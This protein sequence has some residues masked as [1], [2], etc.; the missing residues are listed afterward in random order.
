[1][2]IQKIKEGNSFN[3]YIQSFLIDSADDLD[4]LEQEFHCGFGDEARTPDGTI[5]VR[6][7]DGYSGDKWTIK[8]SGSSGGSGGISGNNFTIDE[9]SILLLAEQELTPEGTGFGNS[10]RTTVSEFEE[11]FYDVE[12]GQKI[13][14]TFNEEEYELFAVSYS[15][16]I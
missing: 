6:H 11:E 13:K 7:S 12:S 2:S 4:N 5:Y 1:M 16:S 3:S 10:Y 14:V 9:T 8:S 15:D